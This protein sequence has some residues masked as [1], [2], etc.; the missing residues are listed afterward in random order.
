MDT[1]FSI[2]QYVNAST[3]TLLKIKVI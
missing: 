3:H 1:K 2:L